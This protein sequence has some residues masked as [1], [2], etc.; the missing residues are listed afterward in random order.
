MKIWK[1]MSKILKF[2]LIPFLILLFMNTGYC[3]PLTNF[4]EA[5]R[6]QIGKTVIYDPSYQVLD[7]PNG[8][9]PIDRGVC[10]DV[11]IRAMRTVFDL[12]LQR[13]VHEDN[14]K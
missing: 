14:Y 7:Y 1:E 12:D 5:A 3:K 6:S 11:I 4:L 9:L 8:D 2:S 10:T 13:L